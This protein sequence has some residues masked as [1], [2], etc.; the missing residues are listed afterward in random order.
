MVSFVVQKSGY[1]KLIT[2]GCRLIM[3]VEVSIIVPVHN[4]AQYLR[5]CLDSVLV[6]SF[7][8]YECICANDASSDSS[9]DV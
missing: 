7:E 8:N 9:L 5:K 6:Q 3:S 4:A 2:L 1:W